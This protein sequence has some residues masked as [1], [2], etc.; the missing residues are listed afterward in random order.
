[1]EERLCDMQEVS[2]S[3]PDAPTE[4][5]DLQAGGPGITVAEATKRYGAP[6]GYTQCACRDCF[7][8][9]VSNDMAHPDFC[10]GCREAG[11]EPD[12]ECQR[13]DAYGVEE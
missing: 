9:V 3:N 12:Q 13:P 11:C 5:F 10:E 4:D 1:M 7:E 6:S 2:G 8:I